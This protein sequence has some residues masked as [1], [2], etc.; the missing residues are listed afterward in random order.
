MTE[1]EWLACEEPGRMLQ[2]LRSSYTQLSQ[3]KLRLF[4]V[5]C[6]RSIVRTD[7]EEAV[8]HAI[9]AVERFAE[10]L[11][12]H[13]E[14]ITGIHETGRLWG[15]D[16]GTDQVYGAVY[17]A[18]H[19]LER[20]AFTLANDIAMISGE[21]A[22]LRA[23]RGTRAAE[24]AAHCRWLRDIFHAPFRP[25]FSKH[26][27]RT[28]NVTALAQAIY[29]DRAFDRLPILAD[30]LEEAGCT[31]AEIL[32]HCRGPGPHVRGCWVVDLILNKE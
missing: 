24:W 20:D 16:F 6:C 9:E 11:S 12:L 3:R 28:S 17:H 5:T 25:V 19:D 14:H 18:A 29:D 8:H 21:A 4:A 22:N 1:Q 10:G 15:I 2:F 13:D 7:D 30:A 31:D 26:S 23:G 32:A 27:W